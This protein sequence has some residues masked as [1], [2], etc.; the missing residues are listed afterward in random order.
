MFNADRGLNTIMPWPELLPYTDTTARGLKSMIDLY[1]I[2]PMARACTYTLITHAAMQMQ[3]LIQSDNAIE[4]NKKSFYLKTHLIPTLAMHSSLSPST[5]HNN[6]HGQRS[7]IQTI[8][9]K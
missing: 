5:L 9:T 6:T 8:I 3:D 7:P 4:F 2:M 1:T